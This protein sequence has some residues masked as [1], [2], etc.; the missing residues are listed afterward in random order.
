MVMDNPVTLCPP[1][2]DGC[3]VPRWAPDEKI[4]LAFDLR[5]RFCLV[6]PKFGL[7]CSTR[8]LYEL[9]RIK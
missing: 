2:F 4:E 9:G 1:F 6:I 8:N 5:L 3:C 7:V